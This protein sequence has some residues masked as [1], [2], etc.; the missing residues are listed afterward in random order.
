MK[1]PFP[2]S[3]KEMKQKAVD[4]MKASQII[5]TMFRT[6]ENFC[7]ANQNNWR[8]NYPN[9]GPQQGNSSFLPSNFFPWPLA[10]QKWLSPDPTFNRTNFR[11]FTLSLNLLNAPRYLNDTPVPIDLSHSRAPNC[12]GEGARGGGRGGTRGHTAQINV[13]NINNA[14][15]KCEQVG[16]YAYN[17]PSR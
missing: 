14:C 12:W 4:A 2:S 10:L 16:H 8:N 11:N 5:Q 7:N 9:Q 1:T 17:C 3:Y 13:Q 15:F 6:Q